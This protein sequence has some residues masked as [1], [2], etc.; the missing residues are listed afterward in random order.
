[1]HRSPA[2]CSV[3]KAVTQCYIQS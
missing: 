1:M 2:Q 3:E